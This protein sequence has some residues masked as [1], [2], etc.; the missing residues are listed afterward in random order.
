[1]VEAGEVQRCVAAVDLLELPEQRTELAD[2]A[3]ARKELYRQL[4]AACLLHRQIQIRLQQAE[5]EL[6]LASENAGQVDGT[7]MKKVHEY[8]GNKDHGD[9]AID[10]D[11][12][13]KTK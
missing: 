1:L 13:E 8:L 6:D 10:L 2:L 3:R 5:M 11:D 4:G 12:L 9:I 7:I